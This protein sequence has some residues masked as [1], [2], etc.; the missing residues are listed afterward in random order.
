[1]WKNILDGHNDAVI[2]NWP[3]KDLMKRWP[4]LHPQQSRLN[5]AQQQ[6]NKIG[7]GP[8]VRQ[9]AIIL[10]D[11]ELNQAFILPGWI[12]LDLDVGPG[13]GGWF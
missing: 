7:R 4:S 10:L 1:M 2:E 8:D 5:S 12:D 11:L 13:G 6:R 3:S 9:E